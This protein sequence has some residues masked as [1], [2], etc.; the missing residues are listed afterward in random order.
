[1]ILLFIFLS[2]SAATAQITLVN[3]LKPFVSLAFFSKW[4]TCVVFQVFTFEK[5]I[6]RSNGLCYACDAHL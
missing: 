4:L 5:E 3:P 2:D 1:M 6:P